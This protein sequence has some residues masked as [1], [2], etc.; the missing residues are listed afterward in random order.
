MVAAPHQVAGTADVTV[1]VVVED[2]TVAAE[3]AGAGTEGVAE[4]GLLVS[5]A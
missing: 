4:V 1:V 3:M 2:A 5:R